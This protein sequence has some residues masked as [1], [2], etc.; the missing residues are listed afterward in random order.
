LLF[1]VEK[2]K[3]AKDG[4]GRGGGRVSWSVVITKKLM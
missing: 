3:K 4:K 2:R 1:A